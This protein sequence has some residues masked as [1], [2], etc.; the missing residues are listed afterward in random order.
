M[1]KKPTSLTDWAYQ[2]IRELLFTGQLL[3][4]KKIVVG[5]LAE[6]L[7]VSPTPVKDALNRLVAEGFL[8]TLPRRGFMVRPLSAKDIQDI[9]ACRK[10][11]EVFAAPLAVQNF[12]KHPEIQ[13]NMLAALDKLGSLDFHD[14]VKATN[15]EQSYHE[16]F[17]KLSENN[18]LIDMYSMIF[19]VG[20]SF[21]VY[22]SSNHPMER[23]D[24]AQ[25]EHRKMYSFLEKGDSKGLQDAIAF[26]LDQ[27]I[28]IYETFS[29]AFT[30]LS[31][32]QDKTLD[33]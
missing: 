32:N 28:A 13:K 20:F 9:M 12:S 33:L 17:V 18:R 4:G 15:L 7:A 10:M 8:D 3:P 31:A 16:S 19:G 2:E 24:E 6:R 25:Q 23:H 21:Y 29:P 11:I 14:Y 5:K 1:D 30:R 27:T 26:H 22:A